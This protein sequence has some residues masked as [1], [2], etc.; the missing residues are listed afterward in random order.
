[1]KS[2]IDI[3]F[4]VTLLVG[5]GYASQRLLKAVRQEALMKVHRGLPSLETFTRKLTHQKNSF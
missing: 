2:V 5:G 4:A 3:I 1:M